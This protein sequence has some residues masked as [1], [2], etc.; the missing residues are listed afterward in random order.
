MSRRKYSV[1]SAQT[2]LCVAFLLLSSSVSAQ[3]QGGGGSAGYG[4]AGIGRPDGVEE[5]DTLKDF[6]HAMAVQA[7]SQQVAEFRI[8]LKST[9]A[10]QAEV[11]KLH[12]QSPG[13][14]AAQGK[15]ALDQTLENARSE[16]EKF[17]GGFSAE[18]KS[19]LKDISRRLEK[20]DSTL[21]QEARRLHPNREMANSTDADLSARAD[22]LG[23][24]L[25][26]FHDQQL[27]LGREM[28]IILATGQDLNFRLPAV[29]TAASVASKNVAVKVSGGLN[30]TAVEGGQRS[31][32]LE[33]TADLS[34]LQQNVTDLLRAQLDRSGGCGERMAIR[35]SSLTPAP[36][37]GLLV[38]SLHFER[39]TCTRA[40]G[41]TSASELAESDG[42]A[43]IRL[44]PSVENNEL[45]LSAGFA[46]VNASGMLADALRSGD[47]GE[48]LR[49]TAAQTVLAAI[50]AATNFKT[51]LPV[52]L[53]SL[54]NV[55]TIKFQD[56]GVGKLIAVLGGQLQ[57]SSE[58]ANQLAG[59]LNQTLSAQ[60]SS[61]R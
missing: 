31:F 12:T 9:E 39:W 20:A 43:E 42:E 55:Q 25:T 47:L 26:D 54:A 24:V 33:M 53:Q 44:I 16:N 49:A 15:A 38:V 19:G 6:H 60:T 40:F 1:L 57:M 37:A 59:Q 46:R 56:G 36:P 48:D 13:V 4:L 32:Q 35:Q 28:G 29:S 18:Q 45:K 23:K 22:T 50:R 3:R 51:T 11:Q 7:T 17:L 8:M 52:A 27:A 61:S 10:A 14:D 34:D 58:Q 21:E 2:F 41:Q 5:K 30:Q